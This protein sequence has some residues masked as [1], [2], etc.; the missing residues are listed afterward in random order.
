MIAEV[1]CPDD[2]VLERSTGD[3]MTYDAYASVLETAKFWVN[4]GQHWLSSSKCWAL[5][6]GPLVHYFIQVLV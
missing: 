3:S 1:L 2:S 5:Y 6:H 4:N